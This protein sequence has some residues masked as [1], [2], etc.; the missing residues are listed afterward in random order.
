MRRNENHLIMKKNLLGIC[1]LALMSSQALAQTTPD[2]RFDITYSSGSTYSHLGIEALDPGFGATWDE[3]VS[4][5]IP[6]PFDFKYQ[7]VIVG[8]VAVET[9]GSLL[10]NGLMSEDF[11]LGNIT[12]I[13]M[14]YAPAGR[15]KILYETTGAEGDRI[16]KVEFQNVGR[17]DDESGNDTLN[18]QVWLYE[19]GNAIEYRAGYSNV[20]DEKFAKTILESVS[21][22]AVLCGLLTNEGDVLTDD[23]AELNAH[24][25]VYRDDA[26][27]DTTARLS[28]LMSDGGAGA[29]AIIHGTYPKNGTVIRF[30]PKETPTG[31]SKIDF[32][33]AS[34][35]PNPST[36]GMFTIRLKDIVESGSVVNIFDINGRLIATQPLSQSEIKI[37]LT[38]V[39]SGQYIGHI[40]NGER[41][42]I[43]KITKQ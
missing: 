16:F 26:Y 7:N 23:I 42:G 2:K 43:F 28:T 21:K 5:P 29:N 17:I 9:Y 22:E 40:K 38:K 32:D 10:L 35:F 24:A 8:N 31:L 4:A 37:D 19:N 12:G 36:D 13:N 3:S 14:A 11:E 34:V 33:L 39:A 1:V 41:V 18:F 27:S 15:G 30:V 20:P 6:M 25:V